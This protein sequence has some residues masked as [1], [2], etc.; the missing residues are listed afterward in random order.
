M[1]AV[2]DEITALGGAYDLSTGQIRRRLLLLQQVVQDMIDRLPEGRV[3]GGW[4]DNRDRVASI[5]ATATSAARRAR[6]A[7]S[8]AA[9]ADD[10]TARRG[11]ARPDG[12][13]H[14]PGFGSDKCH[15]RRQ[16]PAD[17]PQQ[18]RAE[19]PLARHRARRSCGKS[20]AASGIGVVFLQTA[21]TA[22]GSD[23]SR[24]IRAFDQHVLR[25]APT[26][27]LTVGSGKHNK[28]DASP[29]GSGSP[30]QRA[31]TRTGL[32]CSDRCGR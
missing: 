4:P 13:N 18:A 29:W 12:P 11:L 22:E 16:K 32:S 14:V 24:P 8:H 2:L 3:G 27:R 23:Y 10:D 6:T 1:E 7:R 25:P 26:W 31:S 5:P 19:T 28:R 30:L 17:F 21:K 15:S 20:W 9:L